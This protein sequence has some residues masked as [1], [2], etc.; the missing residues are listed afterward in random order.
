MPT[1]HQRLAKN[2]RSQMAKKKMTAERLALEIDKDK[3]HLSR[4][5][6]G[7]KHASLDLVALIADAL[8]V[9]VEDLFSR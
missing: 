1:I 3:G 5:L 6:S 8:K 2:I 4:I 9:D 7:Q